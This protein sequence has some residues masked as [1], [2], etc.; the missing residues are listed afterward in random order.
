MTSLSPKSHP[1]MGD[2]SQKLE[3]WSSLHSSKVAQQVERNLFQGA[4]PGECIV[5]VL[6]AFLS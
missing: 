6:T 4:L 1:S 5:A 2:S 3:S